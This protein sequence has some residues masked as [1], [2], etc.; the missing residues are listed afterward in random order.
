MV[1]LYI[2]GKPVE[3]PEDIKLDVSISLE[4]VKRPG[5]AEDKMHTIAI[6]ITPGNREI[7]GHSEQIM[8]AD[9]FN[10]AEHRGVI[11]SEGIE[12][13][14]GSVKLISC[15]EGGDGA[16]RYIIRLT[17]PVPGWIKS[18]KETI[19]RKT[20]I[21][22]GAM[23]SGELVKNSWT[24]DSAVKF[25][26]VRRDI[27]EEPEYEYEVPPVKIMTYE[28]Y[29]PFVHLRSIL[30]SIVGHAG[31]NISSKFINSEMFDSLYVSGYYPEKNVEL[32]KARMDFFAG[33]LND[34]A[35]KANEEG[36][37]YTT[38]YRANSV[39]NIV[40]TADP[41]VSEDGSRIEGAF[42]NGGCFRSEGERVAFVPSQDVAVG[43]EYRL[44]YKTGFTVKSATELKG[45]DKIRLESGEVH[46]VK[47]YNRMND[48]KAVSSGQRQ[49]A[50]CVFGY[51]PNK[52]YRLMVDGSPI[53]I[54]AA[55]QQVTLPAY[56]S[57][58]NMQENPGSGYTN[59]S[60]WALYHYQ[61]FIEA[62]QDVE[63]FVTLRSAPAFRR[64]G[65]HVYFDNVQFRGGDPGAS[66]T[67]QKGSSLRPVFY[68]NPM[69]GSD[70]EFGEIFAH[71]N[72]QIELVDAVK[73]MFN[74]YF[75]TDDQ[76]KTVFIEPRDAFYNDKITDWPD[77][78]DHGKPVISE[79]MGND[80]EK[81]VTLLYTDLDG[82]VMRSNEANKSK[83]AAWRWDNKSVS[84]KDKELLSVNPLF[85]PT[86]NEEGGF[87]QARSA[88]MM[89]TGDRDGRTDGKND[90][91]LNFAPKIC[92][93]MGMRNLGGGES[94]GYPSY[95]NQYP[96]A[97]F[98]DGEAGG[99][100][101]CFNDHEQKEGL[102][103]YHDSEMEAVN[104]GK[105][106]TAHLYLTAADIY[107]L[108]HPADNVVDFRSLF[109][110]K[111]SGEDVM[112]RL[113][114]VEG[115]DPDS[116]G[117]TKCVFIKE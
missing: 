64:G 50:A 43:F 68:A 76:T 55:Q 22:F 12:I 23:I 60:S 84:A 75:L 28:D 25:L 17:V 91:S 7:F 21:P 77:K 37:V 34:S 99:F 11:V 85:A 53:A 115:Y 71:E 19:L 95:G 82:T 86:L 2:D 27:Y 100:T 5:K 111:L 106:I 6:P 97:A 108:M 94:W 45:F 33:K 59:I 67:L 114:L 89:K 102:H 8:A 13:A 113:A 117:S 92:R 15:E 44:R 10:R 109:R 54:T 105:K 116:Y 78:V 46:Q 93:Y 24:S 69:E 80:T 63:V 112:C 42:S 81:S 32:L 72:K 88:S 4:D 14:K 58:K 90:G 30:K 20:G 31:Y 104:G 98:H 51:D 9:K 49:Y 65:Q 87:P 96:Y 48:V 52:S 38:P 83:Y 36:V 18:A 61:D 66:L 57:V 40:D 26:P 41:T 79:E 47:V 107:N 16:G 35:T 62:T 3:M 74:L 101:L 73:H 110:L 39:G 56:A 70:V 29:H 103:R 1:K